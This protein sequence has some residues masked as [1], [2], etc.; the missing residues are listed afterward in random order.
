M[1]DPP[2]IYLPNIF[3]TLQEATRKGGRAVALRD[4][5][6]DPHPLCLP[7]ISDSLQV[8]T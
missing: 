8:A 4:H 1:H 2:S 3:I 5:M 7:N 6:H